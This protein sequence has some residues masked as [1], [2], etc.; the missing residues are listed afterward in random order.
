MYNREN[1]WIQCFSL[2]QMINFLKIFS[3]KA[4]LRYYLSCTTRQHQQGPCQHLSAPVCVNDTCMQHSCRHLLSAHAPYLSPTY[5]LLC[6]QAALRPLTF[7]MDAYHRYI[8][9][10]TRT[11]ILL[12]G[13]IPTNF[14]HMKFVDNRQIPPYSVFNTV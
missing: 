14:F 8:A 13:Y 5:T 12:T 7:L 3:T 9:P 6:R 11:K 10:L 1:V 4:L 2:T